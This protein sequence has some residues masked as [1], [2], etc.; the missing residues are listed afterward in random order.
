M[1]DPAPAEGDTIELGLE[2]RDWRRIVWT[3]IMAAAAV[4]IAAATDWVNG[5]EFNWKAWAIGAVAAGLSAVKNFV[6]SDSS[7]LK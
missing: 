7:Q 5:G 2:G 6:L 4:L 1:A 3:F